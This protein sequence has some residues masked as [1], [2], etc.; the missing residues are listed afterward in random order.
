ME[1]I[2]ELYDEL[3]DIRSSELCIEEA[4]DYIRKYKEDFEGDIELLQDVIQSFQN[5]KDNIRIEIDEIEQSQ[6]KENQ[7]EIEAM[8]SEFER[9]RL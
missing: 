4:I 5:I 2:E 6:I 1:N 8:N 7:K 9:S 3:E